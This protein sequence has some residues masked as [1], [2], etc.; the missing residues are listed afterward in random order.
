[1]D[2]ESRLQLGRALTWIGRNIELIIKIIVAA[3]G[4]TFVIIHGRG[5]RTIKDLPLRSGQ[6][7]SVAWNTGE[8]VRDSDNPTT[9]ETNMVLTTLDNLH[10]ELQRMHKATS[11][12]SLPDRLGT[13]FSEDALAPPSLACACACA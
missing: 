5:G 2:K 11:V 7:D 12:E 13:A 3:F 8:R 1:M 6:N 10:A 9:H 4:A